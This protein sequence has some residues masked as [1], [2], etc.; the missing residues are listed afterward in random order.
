MYVA[1][2]SPEIAKERIKERVKKGGITLMI[3][4]LIGVIL[5]HL[6]V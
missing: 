5:K 3:A 1:L 6:V 4:L 2:D